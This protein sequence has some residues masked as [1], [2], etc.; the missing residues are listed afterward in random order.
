MPRGGPDA[1][2]LDRLLETD[3][4]EYL[5][6]DDVDRRGQAQRR[7]RPGAH[8]GLVR[9]P[10]EVRPP[11]ARRGRRRARSQDPRARVPDTAGCRPSCCEMHP[12][13][14]VTVTDVEP[15]SVAAIAAG[16]LGDDA[17][18]TVRHDGRHRHRR[19]RRRSSTSRCSRCRS[20][21]CR[22]RC[23]SRVDRRG[24]PGGRQAGDH[25]PA[26][27]RRHRCTCCG[28][29]RCCRS[30]RSS[31]SCTTASSARCA[32]TAR[33][34]CAHWPR[35]RARIDVELR[36]GLLSPQV[37]VASRRLPL[38]LVTGRAMTVPVSRSDV[39]AH[40]RRDRRRRSTPGSA[41]TP[42]AGPGSPRS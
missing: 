18:A 7:P 30:R 19:R 8:R 1:S 32:P 2:C 16:P 20:T 34:R 39:S 29:R 4:L 38:K 5:D 14:H 41:T 21:T 35:T 36:G 10:R 42:T 33:R 3:R 15:D 28:W 26:R 27:G 17:R 6:R 13:A 22:R 11:G 31:R 9:Q 25:R 23:A 40:V 37:A 24:H 12:T